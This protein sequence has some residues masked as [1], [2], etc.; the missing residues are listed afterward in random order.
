MHLYHF[1]LVKPGSINQAISG[2]F[3]GKKYDILTE[4]HYRPTEIVMA[5]GN[6]LELYE[7]EENGNLKCLISQDVFGVI[8]SITSFKF[9]NTVEKDYIAIGSDSGSIVILEVNS[10]LNKFT[11][12]HHETYGKTGCRRIVP[13]QYLAADPKGRALMIGAVE[14]QKFVYVLNMDGDHLTISSPLEGHSQN[15]LVYSM[16]GLDVGFDN[17]A[18]ACIEVNYEGADESDVA[19]QSLKKML[20][21]YELD[22]GKNTIVKKSSEEIDRSANLLIQIPEPLGGVLVCSENYI[23]YK[24]EG[25]DDVRSPI[26]RRSG[27]PQ[28][29]GLMIINSNLKVK[30]GGD[31]FLLAQNELGDLYRVSFNKDGNRVSSVS[32]QY[33]D[34]IPVSNSFLALK[35]GNL[36]CASE[37]GD[38]KCYKIT[39]IE[40]NEYPETYESIG[41][42][43]FP[44]FTPPMNRFEALMSDNDQPSTTNV[45]CLE[46]V[47]E[48]KSLAPVTDMKVTDLMGEGTP[49]IY[50]LNGRGPTS[51]LRSL[52][53]G[54]PVNEEVAA[55]LD[56]QAT[57]IF[58]VKE[59]MNDT[60]DKYI[61]LSFSEFTMV[62]SVGENVAEV[63]ESGFLTTTKTIY[64]SNIGE[65][66]EFVQ[67]HPK[68][69]RHIHPDRVNEWNSG[70]KIIEKAAVNGY[71]IVVSLSGGEI[72][73][74]EYDTSS[75][76]LIETERNDLSQDVACLALS[77]IQDGRT[78]GR[79]LAV[80]FYDKTVRL[81]SLGE[82]DMMSILSRQ[83]L[84]ADPESLSL[85]ELQSGHSRDET[86]LYLNIGLSNGILLRSTVDSSTGELSDT[87]SRF[88]GT[89]GVKLR[90]VKVRGDNAILALSSKP[91][92]GNSI[93]GKIEM[94][95]L[96]YPALNSACNFSSEQIR[97]GLVSITAEHL[98]IITISSLL[99]KFT[100]EI[101]P[102]NYTPRKF[103]VHDETSHMIILQTD[104]NVSKE[105]STDRP[106]YIKVDESQ[107]DPSLSKDV[108]YGAIKTKPKSNLWASYIR[109]YS[110]KKQANLDEFEIEDNEA[111]F[112]ITTCKFSTS[113]SG[114]KSNESLII[115]GTAK[116]MKLYPTRTCD[117]GYINVF[118]ISEDG[119]LQ[120]IHK[121]EVEDVPYA[122]H[123]FRGRLLVGVKNMLR[124][125]DLGKK[126]LLRK[127]ENK[128]FPNF[129]TS[130]AVDGNRIFVGDITESFH[131][132]KF[133]SSEN[134]LTIFADNTTPRWLTASALV[135]HNT[136]AGGDKF[137]NFFISRLPS[138]V[139]DELEDSSTGKE[140]WI[141]ERGLLNG[142]PQKATEIVKFYVGSMI[143]SIY[144]TSLIAGGPSILIYTT[145]TGA[146]GVFFPFTSKKDIEFFTQLEMHLREKN[147]P[148]CGRDHLAYRSY[149]FPVKSVVDGDLIEQFNDVDLQT[150][151]KISEDLQ[152]TINE[153]A[154]KIEDMKNQ[155]GL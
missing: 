22:L 88:L 62:L 68:G 76:N 127:C 24:K 112:S 27:M 12:I 4:K 128:S 99:D 144:K 16:V 118:Q 89:K 65:S 47:N 122:L 95:P 152:R 13:G 124:I 97:D 116:N 75:G 103:V 105:N 23:T 1:T 91:W 85:I 15:T 140:K 104:H 136:I 77:P 38:H 5:K 131:F 145:I 125:Y 54:L 120:L 96:S 30:K 114:A 26:P 63:T 46:L 3:S 134:S 143:T 106:D 130:I 18:F 58:T 29:R 147:P 135:D 92:L 81:I 155:T 137:G 73:Y 20:T 148:L 78:R 59:S 25:Q 74:F 138:D 35:N 94:T 79:F 72:I 80:G 109:V 110:P 86:S 90:N 33:F 129:I 57:A 83:A 52:R 70:N 9:S 11:Q 154:K 14:K 115:V 2:C 60:F 21:I 101:I 67:V 53:Y 31:I 139:S 42:E 93:N 6:I 61:I 121:T 149:Y 132:V 69:I 44:T 141:W 34:T 133:N 32:L 10:N 142:A 49:Q 82:Y 37:F 126:K 8:R 102:L 66:G 87:R 64:A 113:L 111:A 71:Q 108:E 98:R 41:S 7:C 43:T 151:T 150:K 40:P 50:C 19:Y 17:P 51:S 28:E 119:K 55:P 107:K 48:I 123:A 56:Q 36:F 117:C 100:P 45:T 146:V 39:K 153:I 84:P